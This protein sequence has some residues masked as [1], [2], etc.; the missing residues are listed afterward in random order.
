MS[1]DTFVI[2]DES[3]RKFL[4]EEILINILIKSDS[5]IKLAGTANIDLSKY[6]NMSVL[7]SEL[8]TVPLQQSPD[9]NSSILITIEFE[10]LAENLPVQQENIDASISQDLSL[11]RTL[12]GDTSLKKEAPIYTRFENSQHRGNSRSNSRTAIKTGKA[13]DEIGKIFED[14]NIP[15]IGNPVDLVDHLNL[16]SLNEGSKLGSSF[17]QV[18]STS[19][20]SRVNVI[21]AKELLFKDTDEGMLGDRSVNRGRSPNQSKSIDKRSRSNVKINLKKRDLGAAN[22]MEGVQSNPGQPMTNASSNFRRDPDGTKIIDSFETKNQESVMSP[23][24]LKLQQL[25]MGI[26]SNSNTLQDSNPQIKV[27]EKPVNSTSIAESNTPSYLRLKQGS[28]FN[29]DNINS[30]FDDPKIQSHST[31]IIQPQTAILQGSFHG[32]QQPYPLENKQRKETP[33]IFDGG[34]STPAYNPTTL[35]SDFQKITPKATVKEAPLV[36]ESGISFGGQTFI[37]GHQKQN[38]DESELDGIPPYLKTQKSNQTD[39][40]PLIDAKTTIASLQSDLE[41]SKQKILVLESEKNRL[42][43]EHS[44][45]LL[46]LEQYSLSQKDHENTLI[47]IQQTYDA[48]L[49]KLQKDLSSKDEELKSL[50]LERT[51][52][53]DRTRTAEDRCEELS[54]RLDESERLRKGFEEKALGGEKKIGEVAALT[55][56][57]QEME[58]SLQAKDNQL[59]NF[60]RELKVHVDLASRGD[61]NLVFLEAKCKDLEAELAAATSTIEKLQADRLK[62]SGRVDATSHAQAIKELTTKNE[63]INF[64]YEQAN[65]RI[66]DLEDANTDLLENIKSLVPFVY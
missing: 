16:T 31:P 18:P 39:P 9:K 28:G 4:P 30:I 29:N 65:L 12:G 45:D 47:S 11:L 44:K 26:S 59:R 38:I 56:K 23:Q 20:N 49:I 25:R 66:I 50:K 51:E 33:Q 46:T 55:R 13:V 42:L 2:K 57:L 17:N 7:C 52:I 64:K 60:E 8:E 34:Y 3:Q 5:V 58:M 19:V 10:K 32:S 1:F 21:K 53:L 48:K 63:N 35:G 62:S 6:L 40:R 61:A 24:D 22:T 14:C 36:N 27:A 43:S 37:R 41:M 54:R 15:P